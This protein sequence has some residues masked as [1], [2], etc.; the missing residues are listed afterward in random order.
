MHEVFATYLAGFGSGAIITALV[1]WA[2]WDWQNEPTHDEPT[3]LGR[4]PL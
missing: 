3:E 4:W 2:L 1:L